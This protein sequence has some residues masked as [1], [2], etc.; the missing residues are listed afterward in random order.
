MTLAPPLPPV[1]TD[2]A[3]SLSGYA[4]VPNALLRD[5]RVS[6]RAVR[7]YAVLD[8][9][10]AHR[11]AGI[12]V[13]QATLAAD[14]G[15]S[16]ST[17]KRAAE[18]LEEAGW[19]RRRRTGRTSLWHLT[20]PVRDRSQK[21]VQAVIEEATDQRG[22][23]GEP[24]GHGARSVT[25]DLSDRSP[26]T[27]LQSITREDYK[28]HRDAAAFQAAGVSDAS[29]K[30]DTPATGDPVLAAYLREINAATGAQLRP[31]RALRDLVR[32]IAARGIPAEE[33]ALT[34]AAWL[35]AKGSTVTSPA[36]FLAAVALPSLA[37]GTSMDEE[38]P[39]PTPIPPAFRDLQVQAR[40]DH[41]AEAGRC[42]LCRRGDVWLDEPA[43]PNPG[44]QKAL[45]RLAAHRSGAPF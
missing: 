28:H 39:A 2:T 19:L 22:T 45:A 37:N 25:A 44:V 4:V 32:K 30:K 9:R 11:Q 13:G 31:T 5:P 34:A 29:A 1:D 24:A 15:A 17:V 12:R 8:G 20:N 42:A 38:P 43:A 27:S 16:E 35:A 26:V 40:C 7:L 3:K 18:E 33:A 23:G 41:G 10:R 21:A 14:L 6:D 36:G